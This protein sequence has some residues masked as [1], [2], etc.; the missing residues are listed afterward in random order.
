M[1]T[2]RRVNV[3]VIA[4]PGAAAT[5]LPQR[6]ADQMVQFDIEA[7]VS[8]ATRIEPTDESPRQAIDYA[9]QSGPWDS[10]VA[11]GGGSSIDSAKAVD[12]LTTNPAGDPVL[13]APPGG[14]EGTGMIGGAACGDPHVHPPIMRP[15]G[16]RRP[17]RAG[18]G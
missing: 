2:A 17:P 4:D 3:L 11:I 14:D 1:A 8:D 13:P 7:H 16:G 6:V 12:L 5:G 9:R 18:A 15:R 10:Y